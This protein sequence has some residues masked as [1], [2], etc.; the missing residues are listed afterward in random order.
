[1]ARICMLAPSHP[2][3]DPRVVMRESRTLAA[4]GH[5]V[6][7]VALWD[8]SREF[9]EQIKPLPLRYGQRNRLERILLIP[10][11]TRLAVGWRADVYH[12]HEVESLLAGIFAKWITGAKLVFDAHECFHFTAARFQSGW[13]ARWTTAVWKRLLRWMSRRA[14]QVIVVSYSNESFYR[15]FCGCEK[16]TIIHNSPL[17]ELFPCAPRTPEAERTVVHNSTLQGDRGLYQ[18]LEALAIVKRRRPVRF[19]NVGMIAKEDQAG[20][21]ERVRE[22]GLVDDVEVT[23]WLEYEA[24]G[25]ALARG[26]IGLLTLQPTQNN[27][28]TLHNKLFNCMSTGQAIIGPKGSD[29]ELVLQRTD[30][31]LAVD[32][33]DPAA[34]A[35]AILELLENP[36][37]TQ[38]LGRNARR[39]IEE[40]FGW[41]KMEAELARIYRELDAAPAVS[42]G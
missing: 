25:P 35:D 5:E 22:L 8:E 16:V 4:Q 32:M 17:P 28:H 11:V 7:L 2:S 27:Y 9:L 38:Q 18:L 36:E 33:T 42:T 40:E 41:H 20:F 15:D 13:R 30:C 37:R 14:D 1:M 10:K 12:V 6:G 19:L 31:G 24:V 21:E 29:T 26:A 39:A 23:G 3:W 34:L